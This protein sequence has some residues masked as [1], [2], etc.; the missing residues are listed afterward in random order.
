MQETCE[1]DVISTGLLLA[2]WRRLTDARAEADAVEDRILRRVIEL[3]AGRGY[4]G[5]LE[6]HRRRRF[7]AA[8]AQ[9]ANDAAVLAPW[10]HQ[11]AA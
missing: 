3:R 6:A 2:R 9:A 11:D 5:A 10:L 1:V 4:I 7:W 8:F